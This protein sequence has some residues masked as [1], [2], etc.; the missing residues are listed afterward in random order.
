[1]ERLGGRTWSLAREGRER[2]V[3]DMILPPFLLNY[4]RW[5]GLQASPSAGISLAH[6]ER[7]WKEKKNVYI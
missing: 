7:I 1:M 3:E 6:H 2:R 4:C 5:N